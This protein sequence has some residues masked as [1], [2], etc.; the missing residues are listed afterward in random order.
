MS[1]LKPALAAV[2]LYLRENPGVV[3]FVI[4]EA[5]IGLAHF[6]VH[7]TATQLAGVFAVLMPILLGY[8]HVARKSAVKAGTAPGG[9][10]SSPLGGTVTANQG[11]PDSNTTVDTTVAYNRTPRPIGV[12]FGKPPHVTGREIVDMIH[13]YEKR[14][15]RNWR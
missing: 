7:V 1:S 14:G 2:V 11:P 8:F 13:E 15:G 12:G 5:V 10:N 3:S 6:G 4:G 9:G